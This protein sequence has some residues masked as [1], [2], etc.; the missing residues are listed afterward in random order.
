MIVKKEGKR[1]GRGKEEQKRCGIVERMKNGIREIHFS[2]KEF[3]GEKS[4]R[5][6]CIRIRWM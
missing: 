4:N 2:M 5:N 6:E 3:D 1:V